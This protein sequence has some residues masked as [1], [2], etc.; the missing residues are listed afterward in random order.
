[1][2][3]AIFLD[4]DGTLI[5]DKN[6][7]ADPAQVELVPGTIEALRLATDLGYLLFLFTNQSGIGRNFFT[8]DI[9][10]KIHE[11]MIEMIGLPPPLFTETCIAPETPEQPQA[12]RKPSP[13]F[14]LEM[15][16]K[17]DLDARQ[18]YMAGD[19]N[20]DVMAGFMGGIKP[21]GISGPRLKPSELP[22]EVSNI[23]PIFPSLL[24]FMRHL[25]KMLPKSA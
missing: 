15:M 3:K 10:L 5:I 22:G 14:I 25:D 11:R 20:S 12:Y 21:I 1:M 16:R 9:V 7:L 24:D 19:A 8:M 6:Y 4:R 17:Y 23:L 2:K 18:C 13:R